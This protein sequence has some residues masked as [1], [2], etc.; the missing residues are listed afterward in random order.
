VLS[1]LSLCG[2]AP[3]IGSSKSLSLGGRLG[4]D[5]ALLNA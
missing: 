2:G 5:H 1:L 4:F 3:P